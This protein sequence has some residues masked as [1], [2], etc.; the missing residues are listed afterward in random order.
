MVSTDTDWFRLCFAHGVVKGRLLEVG[1]AEVQEWP[2]ICRTAREL[3][4]TDTFGVDLGPGRGVD[5]VFDFSVFRSTFS[6]IWTFGSFQTVCVF[7][8]LEHTFDPITVLANALSCL[9]PGGVLLVLTPSVWPIHSFPCDYVRLLPDWY[10]AFAKR[11]DLELLRGEFCWISQFGITPVD[12]DP[13]PIYPTFESQGRK[14]S[15]LRYWISKVVHK[16]FN[17]YGRSHWATYAALAV[18]FRKPSD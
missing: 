8:V 9:E 14:F 16:L 1:S 5:E 7:N 13:E 11:Y 12:S 17:T 6:Q 15:P 4:I 3:G 18:A 10:E 2:N